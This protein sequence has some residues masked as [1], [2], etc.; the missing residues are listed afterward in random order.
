MAV[1]LN[2]SG[3]T[4]LRGPEYPAW[5]KRWCGVLRP[6]VGWG[7][8]AGNGPAFVWATEDQLLGQDYF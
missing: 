8:G 5:G 7:E 2:F 4:S 3:G 1:A 6:Q